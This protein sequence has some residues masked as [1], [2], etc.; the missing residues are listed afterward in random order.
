MNRPPTE[1]V[2]CEECG[3]SISTATFESLG[4]PFCEGGESA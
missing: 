1:R 3:R 4:C 2:E